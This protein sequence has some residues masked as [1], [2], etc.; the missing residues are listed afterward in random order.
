MGSIE[1][2]CHWILPGLRLPTPTASS[3]HLEL[4]HR[5]KPGME[6]ATWSA[7]EQTKRGMPGLRHPPGNRAVIWPC[8]FGRNQQWVREGNTTRTQY[9][10]K[11]LQPSSHTLNTRRKGSRVE[12]HP[13]NGV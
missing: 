12:M 10:G 8:H 5:M 4:P 9:N 6:H 7:G 11:C 13:C 3:C 1:K 2:P